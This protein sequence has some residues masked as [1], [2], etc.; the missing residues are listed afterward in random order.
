[1]N[2]QDNKITRTYQSQVE[3]EKGTRLLGIEF[4]HEMLLTT[5]SGS[6]SKMV[7]C[8]NLTIEDY[9]QILSTCEEAIAELTAEESEGF[10]SWWD[11]SEEEQASFKA[12]ILEHDIQGWEEL[13]EACAANGF[14]ADENMPSLYEMKHSGQDTD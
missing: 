3:R 14:E 7:S 5:Y 11:L 8:H 4:K 12:Y 9:K 10:K 2:K 1:M 6:R 13:K